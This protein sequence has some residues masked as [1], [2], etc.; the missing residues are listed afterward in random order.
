MA[1]TQQLRCLVLK[2]E[3]RF[4]TLSD[5]R[6]LFLERFSNITHSYPIASAGE[7]LLKAAETGKR[8]DTEAATEQ[9][10]RVLTSNRF[11][12]AGNRATVL[13]RNP[14]GTPAIF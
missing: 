2:D 14:S 13:L 7:L 1:W 12:V 5:V 8:A 3:R 11:M 4:L 9:I 10:E 6:A